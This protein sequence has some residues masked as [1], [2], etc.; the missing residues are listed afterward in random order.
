MN[1]GT[2][3]WP[4][5]GI[6]FIYDS[7]YRTEDRPIQD[8]WH[9]VAPGHSIDLKVLLTAPKNPGNYNVIWVLKVGHKVF[10]SMKN[11]FLVK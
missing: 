9:S 3:V 6:D 2:E 1:T 5:T 10:C 11:V 4:N 8:L 7:G